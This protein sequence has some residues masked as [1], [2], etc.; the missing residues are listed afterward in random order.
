MLRRHFSSDVSIVALGQIVQQILTLATGIMIA[1]MVGAEG[2]GILNLLRTVLAMILLVAPLGLDLALLKHF[3]ASSPLSAEGARMLRRLRLIAFMCNLFV[4]L[5]IGGLLSGWL[6][7]HV[8]GIPGFGPL[9]ALTLV[10]LPLAADTAILGACYRALERPGAFALM[11]LYFQSGLR[12]VLVLAVAL[13]SPSVTAIAWVNVIQVAASAGLVAWYYARIA[14]PASALPPAGEGSWTALRS[15]LAGSLMMSLNLVAYGLMRFID[16]V[17]LGIWGSARDV[18]E[19]GALSAISQLVQV[20]PLAASQSLGPRIARHHAAGDTMAMRRELNRYLRF[21]VLV[22]SFIFAG[23]AAFGDRLDLVFGSSFVFRKDV[24]F[25]VPL[26][27]LLSATL[28]PMGF[29]LSMTGRHKSEFGLLAFGTLVLALG[30]WFLVP[31]Y[32]QLGAAISVAMSF[33][34]VNIARFIAVSRLLGFVPGH[35]RDF[36]APF[37]ALALA[38]AAQSGLEYW[39]ARSLLSTFGACLAYAISYAVLAPLLLL[40]REA[41]RALLTNLRSRP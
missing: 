16:I 6:E 35:W 27:F 22:A 10:A 15:L 12:L 3:G 39:G 37:L 25:L 31:L 23:I 40:D 9:L 24:A 7:R 5:L 34:M 28:A 4:A 30:C 21:A 32:G 19:Y 36:V 14:T 20:Y 18:G 41:R 26:G 13:A 11:T 29:A 1:R 17:S 33:A 2:Y 38:F 8:F